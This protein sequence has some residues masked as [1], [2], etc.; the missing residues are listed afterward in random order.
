M[1]TDLNLDGYTIVG[2]VLNPTQLAELR[3][4][5]EP[6]LISTPAAGIRGLVKKVPSI[7]AVAESPTLRAQVTPVL[8]NGAQ[9]IRS[10]L[11]NKDQATNWQ[12][13][14]H[15]DLAIAVQHQT[16]LAGFS[17]WSVKEGVVH[18]QPPIAVLEHMLT[19]RLHLDDTDET[20]G[21][22]WVS[23]GT[24]R[25]GRILAGDAATLA[26]HHGKQLCAVQAGD[27]LLFRPLLLHASRK[28]VTNTPRRVIHLEFTS[29]SLPAPLL[30]HEMA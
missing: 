30:W 20:N 1:D 10:V 4:S 28:T 29:A 7:R 8:G 17:A 2:G 11:F 22:L 23:P 18:V 27:A 6:L 13:A 3:I 12:V 14:W 15:Q 19:V 26:E 9:L 25:L 24:H 5:V 16:E 21:A